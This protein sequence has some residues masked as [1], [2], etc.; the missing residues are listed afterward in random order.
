MIDR[1]FYGIL[2]AAAVLFAAYL[3]SIWISEFVLR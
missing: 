2:A 1:I 3:A